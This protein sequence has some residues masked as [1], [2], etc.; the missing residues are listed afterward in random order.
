MRTWAG[1][2]AQAL[3]LYCLPS[4]SQSDLVQ[5]KHHWPPSHSS[6]K[7]G[8]ISDFCLV[9]ALVSCLLLVSLSLINSI[10]LYFSNASNFLSDV[11]IQ[12]DQHNVSFI[13]I[14]EIVS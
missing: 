1:G 13:K 2:L 8:I 10:S 11:F 6:K 5:E 12:S 9:P 4:P 3:I 14:T 7:L